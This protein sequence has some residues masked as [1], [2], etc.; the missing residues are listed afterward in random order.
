MSRHVILTTQEDRTSNFRN[1][2]PP[3][4][5]MQ[6][7]EKTKFKQLCT[8]YKWATILICVFTHAN[9]IGEW[10]GLIIYAI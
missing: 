10:K 4:P 8:F 3:K 9:D 1:V 6:V 5:T 7:K 2:V